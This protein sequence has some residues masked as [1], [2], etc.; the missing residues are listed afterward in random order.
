M[1]P[2]RKVIKEVQEEKPKKER[3]IDEILKSIE[4]IK[5]NETDKISDE[6]SN[7]IKNIANEKQS[8]VNI[9]NEIKS[10]KIGDMEDRTK[11]VIETAKQKFV[12]ML[13]PEK[14]FIPKEESLLS[15]IDM[16]KSITEFFT[17]VAANRKNLYYV[18]MAFPEK[19]KEMKQVIVSLENN[20]KI[21]KTLAES[22]IFRKVHLIEQ[23]VKTIKDLE[24]RNSKLKDQI[25]DINNDITI[26]KNSSEKAKTDI[27]E[28]KSSKKYLEYLDSIRKIQEYE[29]DLE[30]TKSIIM[31]YL[32]PLHRPLKRFQ[33][34]VIDKKRSE[35]IGSF[36]EDPLVVT[37][38]YEEFKKL[39]SDL[40]E[41]I[42]KDNI[43]T[44]EKERYL[45][46]IKIIVETD[47]LTK[48]ISK[49]KNLLELI[50]EQKK[51]FSILDRID[52]LEKEASN[53]N[54]T[55]D[56]EKKTSELERII[57][58]NKETILDL[59]TKI[60]DTFHSIK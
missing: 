52:K 54:K 10:S 28:L 18:S 4:E 3:T 51:D 45:K 22:D 37:Q 58:K 19:I 40:L 43:P 8:L 34:T 27:E 60:L 5:K 6:A 47:S 36:L 24:N 15:L 33:R 41:S 21:I 29:R 38:K 25:I 7:I 13:L 30:K 12:S 53:I 48:S 55:P 31:N 44:E 16:N 14:I 17:N 49:Y 32:S 57:S 1:W 46:S 9:V 59:K 26:I 2:F 42:I 23:N 35:M 50:N 56:M 20:A 39:F 11:K